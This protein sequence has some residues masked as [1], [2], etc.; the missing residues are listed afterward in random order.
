MEIIKVSLRDQVENL[1][2]EIRSTLPDIVRL[3]SRFLDQKQVILIS[4]YSPL[5]VEYLIY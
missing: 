4:D 2:D 1:E 3:S 5:V